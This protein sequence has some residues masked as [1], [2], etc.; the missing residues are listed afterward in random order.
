MSHFDGSNNGG[1]DCDRSV[2]LCYM[3]CHVMLCHVM[4]Y[5]MLCYVMLCYVICYML[6][7]ICYIPVGGNRSARRKPT[8][9][10]RV[11]TNSFQMSA[12]LGSSN[13][14]NILS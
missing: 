8:T 9:F 7:V 11:L 14:E 12:T 2:M 3:L 5:V 10:G 6:Y 13:T 4:L 1:T